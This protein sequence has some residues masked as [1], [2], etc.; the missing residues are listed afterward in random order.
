MSESQKGGSGVVPWMSESLM[1][2]S[3]RKETV[4]LESEA[5]SE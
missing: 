3:E 2:I 5:Q 4:L 1:K